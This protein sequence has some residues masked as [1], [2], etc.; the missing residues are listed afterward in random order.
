MP[1]IMII[2]YWLISA[3]ICDRSMRKSI[4]YPAFRFQVLL[5]A[6]IL[7][8]A[9]FIDLV[10]EWIIKDDDIVDMHKKLNNAWATRKEKEVA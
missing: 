10:A 9:A 6:P 3:F 1:T 5:L 2:L 4:L 7:A 8:P